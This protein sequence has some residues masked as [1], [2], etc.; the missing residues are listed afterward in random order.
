VWESSVPAG[1]DDEFVPPMQDMEAKLR[2]E[3]RG[4][5]KGYAQAVAFLRDRKNSL[6]AARR[7]A[8]NKRDSDIWGAVAEGSTLAQVRTLPAYRLADGKTQ[9]AVERYFVDLAERTESRAAARESRAAAAEAREVAAVTRKEKE[10]EQN[11][12]SRY[13]ELSQPD[14]LRQMNRGEILREIP[15]L[16]IDHVN[17]LL[18]DQEDLQKSDAVVRTATIDRETFQDIAFNAGLDYAYNTPAQQ[19]EEQKARLGR[20][21]AQTEAAIAAEQAEKRRALSQEEKQT[22]M[23]DIV[24]RRVMLDRWTFD[25]EMIAA[26]VQE[27]EFGNTYVPLDQI[28]AARLQVMVNYIKGMP[29]RAGSYE[30]RPPSDAEIT[31]AYKDKLQ[32]AYAMVLLTGDDA[33]AWA[34]LE[35]KD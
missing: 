29:R 11:G 23:R 34:I 13:Y 18:K 22:V 9:Q 7:D 17:R 30:V 10:K 12:W 4:D 16:G 19:T 26:T 33:K 35:A 25:K 28:P 27:N 5:A 2:A 14:R 3:Y 32:R 21:R 15:T 31:S 6:D 24:G 20:L 8:E 1:S